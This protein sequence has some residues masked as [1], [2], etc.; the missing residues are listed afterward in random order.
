MHFAT[1]VPLLGLG[2]TAVHL[3]AAHQLELNLDTNLTV[4]HDRG[5]L[6]HS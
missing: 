6:T 5:R 3:Q 4:V 1:M 2:E